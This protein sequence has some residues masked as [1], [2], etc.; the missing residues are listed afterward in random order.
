MATM[1]MGRVTR[2]YQGDYSAEAAYELNDI[3]TYTDG[4]V[5]WHY[6][7]E[8]TTGVDC[9][10]SSVWALVI[11]SSGIPAMVAAAQAAQTAAQ[12]A[13]SASETAKSGAET[14]AT[15]A[16]S[17]AASASENAAAAKESAE[18]AAD[19]VEEATALLQQVTDLV[20]A[21]EDGTYLTY[22]E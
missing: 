3:V 11:D 6:S 13:Q 10:D 21:L 20:N 1:D 22:K 15:N 7:R 12:T 9:T 14:A 8:T 2:I 17:Y 18:N 19:L 5:Y 4:S 16:G